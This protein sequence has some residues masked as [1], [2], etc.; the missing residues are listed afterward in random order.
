MNIE[1]KIELLKSKLDYWE[2]YIPV[3]NMG[4]WSTKTR[5]ESIKGKIETLNSGIDIEID[6]LTIDKLEL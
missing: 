3:N 5:I 4:K 1:Q 2:N 6:D